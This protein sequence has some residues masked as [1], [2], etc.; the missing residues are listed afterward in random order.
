MDD[1]GKTRDAS[2]AEVLQPTSTPGIYART[3]SFE[4]VADALY[5]LIT[6]Y[7][8]P[9]TEVLRFP[10]VMSRSQLET[11][12]YL[13]TF[14]HLLGC[15]SCLDADAAGEETLAAAQNGCWLSQLKATD[16][17][18]T[19]AA[20]YPVY[21]MVANRGPLRGDAAL[22]DV[23]SYCFRHE[24]ST[25]LDRLQSFQMREY[26]CIGTAKAVRQFRARWMDLAGALAQ[27][28][29][30]PYRIAPAT[31]PFFGRVGKLMALQQVEQALKFELLVS[32]V[33]PERPTACMSFNYHQ[34][35]FGRTWAL[36]LESGETAHTGCVA[37][38]LDRLVIALFAQ[39]GSDLGG[40]PSEVRE[41]LELTHI[42]SQGR[43]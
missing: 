27:A 36:R 24:P 19:P 30:L 20:C 33:E 16:L 28:L 23:A 7:R 8:P 35:H 9:R 26:V 18:L 4:C 42:P 32:A 38:G 12:G 21:P 34:D 2:I 40:W 13:Q 29:R 6:R 37:F 10:P 14:P 43:R 3:A 11:A 22:F 15:V 25:E 31:D 5:A 1:I 17:V 41:V 39:H